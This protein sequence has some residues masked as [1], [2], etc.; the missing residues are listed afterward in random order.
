MNR[1][2]I[3]KTLTRGFSFGTYMFDSIN[4][5]CLAFNKIINT[6]GLYRFKKGLKID[7]LSLKTYNKQMAL[8]WHYAMKGN[9]LKK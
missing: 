8:A 4:E 5:E 2:E 3:V 6:T 1:S 7:S 9:N